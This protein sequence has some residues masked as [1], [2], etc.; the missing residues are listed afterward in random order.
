MMRFLLADDHAMFRSGLRRILEAEFAGLSVEEHQEYFL[1]LEDHGDPLDE[2]PK[3]SPCF[4]DWG[5]IVPDFAGRL[6]CGTPVL[7]LF[8]A[9]FGFLQFPRELLNLGSQLLLFAFFHLTLSKH[10]QE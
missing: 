8:E 2:A 3:S 5:D 9:G 1:G 6:A 4:A 10:L 7:N